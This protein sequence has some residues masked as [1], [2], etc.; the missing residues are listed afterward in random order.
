VT[1]SGP[2]RWVRHPLYAGSTLMGVGLAVAARAP[3]V[4]VIVAAYLALMLTAA[5]RSEE[6]ALR[7]RFGPAYDEYARGAV[8]RSRRFSLARAWRNREYRAV[9][10]LTV[11]FGL[12]AL[13]T[14]WRE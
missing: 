13:K 7:A 8:D 1:R 14:L 11:S 9:L 2:Y 12:L 6:A 4:A 5:I 10:G 3:V